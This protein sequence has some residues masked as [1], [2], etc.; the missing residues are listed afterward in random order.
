MDYLKSNIK[1]VA[2]VI[3]V[4]TYKNDFSRIYALFLDGDFKGEKR[5]LVGH[6]SFN[7]GFVYEFNLDIYEDSRYG[8]QFKIISYNVTYQKSKEGIINFLKSKKFENIGEKT[9]TKIIEH[10]GENAIDIILNN[11]NVLL[12]P[13]LSL[14]VSK[15]QTIYKNLDLIKNEQD[16]KERLSLIKLNLSELQINKIIEKYKN[17]SFEIVSQ[18]PYQLIKDIDGISFKKADAIAIQFLISLDSEYRIKAAINY[19]LKDYCE[20]ENNTYLTF[21]QLYE[22]LNK[23]LAVNIDLKIINKCIEELILE[24][25]IFYLKE[26]DYY[27]SYKNFLEEY[28]ISK[29]IKRLNIKDKKINKEK[30]DQIVNSLDNEDL[31]YTK[32]QKQAIYNS[33][34]NNF[35]I[36]TGGP[37]TGKT[38]IIKGIIEAY[39]RY[40]KLKTIEDKSGAISLMA[41]TGRA[42]KRMEEVLNLEASTIHK[43]LK[44][45]EGKFQVNKENRL[46]NNLIIVDEASMVDQFIC[47]KLLESIKKGA[48]TIFVGDVNQLPS[49]GLGQV[50]KDIILSQKVNVS[51]LEVV[52]RQKKDSNILELAYNINESNINLSEIDTY[53]K[54]SKFE[55]DLLYRNIDEISDLKDFFKKIYKYIVDMKI[56]LYDKFQIIIPQ[57]EGDFGTNNINQ[58]LSNIINVNNQEFTTIFDKKFYLNDKVILTKNDYTNGVMNGEIGYVK[59][60]SKDKISVSFIQ[61]DVVVEYDQSNIENIQLAYAITVH[62]SQG[63]EYKLLIFLMHKSHQY[64][65]YKN[66]LYTAV[67]RAKEKLVIVGDYSL[68]KKSN[69]VSKDKQTTLS[70][71]LKEDF[72]IDIN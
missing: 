48:K 22:I 70:L 53:I 66:L 18:N 68:L 71:F 50:L 20:A 36:I 59:Q 38:T 63:S 25:E 72:N 11:K 9:A 51:Y 21:N 43:T 14:P 33:L 16:F 2:K 42:A 61:S 40:F 39:S 64:M 6:G 13:P 15:A 60:V 32:N 23:L 69:I 35:S 46:Y 12:Q 49:V 54:N 45:F 52:H 31:I 44:Y 10:L 55:N 58:I 29:D 62:K 34:I 1:M 27:Y 3:S 8:M 56:D 65:L 24:N 67:T 37:G 7:E 19:I 28:N 4:K 47:S 5:T 41:P 17:K 57:K 26:Q 30:L